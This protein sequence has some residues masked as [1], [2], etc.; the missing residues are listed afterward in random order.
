MGQGSLCAMKKPEN[1][2][3][4]WPV[5]VLVAVALAGAVS[6][7]AAGAMT[8]GRT[9]QDP[10]GDPAGQRRFAKFYGQA[11][12]WTSCDIEAIPLQCARVRV[13]VDWSRPDGPVVSL[14]VS[15]H[16]ATGSRR[17]SLLL[18]PGGPGASGVDFVPQAVGGIGADLVAAYDLVGWDP[19]GSGRSHPLTCP[20]GADAAFASADGSPDTLRER[21]AYE[22]A[23]AGW[24]RACMRASGPLF[25]HVD[26]LS[27]ARDMDVLRAV[28]K[29]D[30]LD[31]AGYSYG[32]V[33]GYHY[34][35]LFPYRVGRM[36]L[37]SAGDPTLDYRAWM[38]GNT[39]AKEDALNG[40]LRSCDDRAGCPFHGMTAARARDWLLALLKQADTTPLPVTGGGTVTQSM[41]YDAVYG[42]LIQPHTWARLDQVLAALRHG[43]AGPALEASGE[44]DTDPPIT[45]ANAAPLCLDLPDHRDARQV[46]ADARRGER[47]QPVFSRPTIAGTNTVCARWPVPPVVRPHPVGAYGA[48]PILVVGITHDT[49]GPYAWARSLSRQLTSGRLLTYDG[50]GHGAVIASACARTAEGRYLIGGVLPAP[51]TVCRT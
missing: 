26:S 31:Y 18:D 5:V 42:Q 35:D 20:A 44:K 37:D 43:D 24:A 15:R 38:R 23:A 49:A 12:T 8:G 16:L 1:G 32:T 13:P 51:G 14:A 45:I 39:S 25:A 48:A 22:T 28:L 4:A 30:R 29:E 19:R 7:A 6:T 11:V 10:H 34:A 9:G 3:L 46:M 2:R 17:G 50:Y 33:L 27:T 41:L 47:R 40:Y 36:V 21:R